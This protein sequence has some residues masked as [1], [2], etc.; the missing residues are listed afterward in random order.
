MEKRPLILIT[1]DDGYKSPGIKDITAV[2]RDF[3]DVV[4]VGPDK[5]HSGMSHAVTLTKPIRFTL[6]SEEPGLKVYSCTGTPADCVKIALNQIL[7][8]RPDLLL[9]GIN[10]GSNSS[11]SLFYSGTVAACI[12]GCMNGINS[13][14]LSVDDHSI[15]ADFRLAHKY[16]KRIIPEVLAQGLPDSTCLNINFPKI[17]PEECRGIKVC[18]QAKG[19]WNEEFDQRVD[20]YGRNYY[21]LTGYFSNLEPGEVD[22]DDWALQQNFA[23]IV[24]IKVDVTNYE[25]ID[26]I[27]KWKLDGE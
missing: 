16:A 6:K 9:S 26:Q 19:V 18:R 21:W 8:R 3:G 20:P 12:E 17:S 10:H 1:N 23:V 4:V 7:D 5:G 27:K 14:A 22:T 24:P 2:A 11:V 15:N 25:A 13:I